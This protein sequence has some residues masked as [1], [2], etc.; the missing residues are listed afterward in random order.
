M[1]FLTL[2]TGVI[3]I[4]EGQVKI[5][6]DIRYP[7][8]VDAV[9]MKAQIAKQIEAGTLALT[10]AVSNDSAPLYVDPKSELVSTLE[11]IYRKHSGDETTPIMTIGGG[12][13]ARNFDQFV[14]YGPEL[15]NMNQNVNMK[16][17]GPHQEDEG[18][19]I[20]D[21]MMAMAIYAESIAALAGETA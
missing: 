21:L 5:V 13:Y 14:A 8:D 10:L 11:A 12:T 3:E 16:I 19:Q 4:K 2:N 15:P 17:G 6:N 7:I 9:Q 20:S 18:I 1:G